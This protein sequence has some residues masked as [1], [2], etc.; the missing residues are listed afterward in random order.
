MEKNKE[1]WNK[2][3]LKFNEYLKSNDFKTAIK[4]VAKE[5]NLT[6][7]EAYKILFPPE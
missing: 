2:C 1:F 6:Y 5:F 7:K 3:L 4:L